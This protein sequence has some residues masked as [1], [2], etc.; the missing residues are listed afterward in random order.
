M[1]KRSRSVVVVAHSAKEINE[2]R[3]DSR[4]RHAWSAGATVTVLKPVK[5]IALIAAVVTALMSPVRASAQVA[6]VPA[7]ADGGGGIAC[8]H[9][10]DTGNVMTDAG[11]VTPDV[12]IS[13]SNTTL[14]RG[15]LRSVWVDSAGN[16]YASL[17]GTDAFLWFAAGA[18]GNVAPSSTI[19]GSN[20]TSGHPYRIIT[21]ASGNIWVV[22]YTSSTV[23]K[24]APCASG[25]CNTA[26]SVVIS[27]SN[28]QLNGP[29]AMAFDTAGDLWVAT[30]GSN[31]LIEFTAAQLVSGGNV[32]P[33]GNTISGDATDLNFPYDMAIDSAGNIYVANYLGNSV[34]VYDVGHQSG[35]VTPKRNIAGAATLLS[36]PVGVAVDSASNIYVAQPG[37]L[38][39]FASG[40]TGNVAPTTNITG[41][42]ALV[43][44][45]VGRM[46]I[47]QP[48]QESIRAARQ[49]QAVVIRSVM[50]QRIMAGG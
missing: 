9:L 50:Q 21:D 11:N 32:A 35:N 20:L 10:T 6:C 45:G 14:T 17:D 25:T 38:L 43:N 34:T 29:D 3:R 7:A 42:S 5:R 33:A 41:A 37:N 4:S 39:S 27:G 8:F 36:S 12:S 15:A 31:A 48:K 18:N 46:G 40:T 19:T 16:Y 28:T 49:I 30:I 44:C 23:A 26:P 24:Y 2:C 22:S 13:G 47:T 1:A